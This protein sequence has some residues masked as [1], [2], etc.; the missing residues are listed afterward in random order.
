MPE[1]WEGRSERHTLP[2]E[3]LR[4]KFAAESL[5]YRCHYT[6]TTISRI[7]SANIHQARWRILPLPIEQFLATDK[8]AITAKLDR[9]R[10]LLDFFQRLA[11]EASLS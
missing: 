3:V 10:L 1:F 6:P 8:A 9:Y 2:I 11:A 5:F 4:K 7:C